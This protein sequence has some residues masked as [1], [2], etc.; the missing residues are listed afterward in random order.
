MMTYTTL[1]YAIFVLTFVFLFSSCKS[2]KVISDGTVNERLSAKAVIK[3][4]YQNE[5]DFKTLRGKVKIDYSDGE[6][7]KSVSVSLRMEKNKAIWLSAPFGVGKVYI[8]PERVSFYNKLQNEY[9]DGDFSYL[10]K[11]LGTEVD[12][13]IVQNLLLGQALVDLRDEKYILSTTD[14]GYRLT[15]KTAGT[16]YKILFQIEPQ[17]FKMAMQQL[18]QPLE[19]RLLTI[20]YEDYQ[21]VQEAILPNSVL[22]KATASEEENTIALE[23]R[24]L[25]LNTPLNF[26]YKIPKGFKE[27]V[28]K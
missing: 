21:K 22:V 1:R 8:S 23:Y 4:H 20:A 15:P 3:A 10:S 2:K 5:L 27:I 12:F 28:L 14:K 7:S 19:K 9:F 18:S 13:S 6:S 24:N 25:E 16:L 11:L 26:P 17:N